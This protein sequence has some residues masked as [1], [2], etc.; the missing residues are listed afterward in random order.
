MYMLINTIIIFRMQVY[1]TSQLALWVC[2]HVHVWDYVKSR[3]WNIPQAMSLLPSTITHAIHYTFY[4]LCSVIGQ[5]YASQERPN[6]TCYTFIKSLAT[7]QEM[8]VV[9]PSS[10]VLIFIWRVKHRQSGNCNFASHQ[11]APDISFWSILFVCFCVSYA[12]TFVV[13]SVSS[14]HIGEFQWRLWDYTRHGYT[15]SRYSN[16]SF[17][18]NSTAAQFCITRAYFTNMVSL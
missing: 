13:K 2:I 6:K 11:A 18:C 4:R 17:N 16:H 3:N 7:F 9:R 10:H 15:L 1:L 5:N 8:K 14:L 12:G